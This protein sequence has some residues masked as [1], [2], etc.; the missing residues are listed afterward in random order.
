MDAGAPAFDPD[1]AEFVPE[2]FDFA[3]PAPA[4]PAAAPAREN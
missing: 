1:A 2:G 4:A 3:A